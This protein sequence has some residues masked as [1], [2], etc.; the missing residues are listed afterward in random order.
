MPVDAL[1]VYELCDLTRPTIPP[2]SRLHHLEPIGVGTSHVESLT[3]YVARLAEAHSVCTRTL[4]VHELLPLLGRAHLSKRVDSSLSAFW[5]KESRALNGTRTLAS[6]WVQALE[7]LTLRSDLRFLTLLTLADVLTPGGLLRPTRAWCPDCY[8]EWCEAGQVIYEPLLWALRVVAACPRHRRR[9]L[10]QCPHPDCRQSMPLLA[11]RSRPGYCSRCEHWL[12]ALSRAEATDSEALSE[13]E[14][15]WQA[16]VVD[17]VGELLAAAPNLPI[18]PRRERIAVAVSACVEQVTGG[19]AKALAHEL[20]ISPTA[21]GRWRQGRHVPQLDLF[22]RV[23]Y[24]CGVSPLRLLTEGVVVVDPSKMNSP[25]WSELTCTPKAHRRP[26]D[27]NGVRCALE[28]VLA[29]DVHPPPPMSE[30]ARRLEYHH[31]SLHKHFPELCRDISAR[32]L[33]YRKSRGMQRR[34]RLCEEVRQAAYSVHAQG[35]YPSAHR[36]APLLSVPG[37]VR[38]PDAI[39]TQHE[40][41]RELGWES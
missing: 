17:A 15:K 35:M 25:I 27:A 32:Y 18:S 40:V 38:H 4:V 11:S 34:Q 22:L 8:Q 23:C 12:G 39:A 6:D 37:S 30:I 14:T 7:T 20:R 24:R 19:N 10:T 31:S 9:L 26:F 36:I 3:G 13:D 29:S 41:L 1:I 21:V 16:W 5:S 33:A 2:H 28:A